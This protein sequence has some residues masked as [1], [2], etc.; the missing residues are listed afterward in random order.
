MA[1]IRKKARSKASSLPN[2]HPP[3]RLELLPIVPPFF[4]Q[5]RNAA[6][7]EG[8]LVYYGPAPTF[9]GVGEVVDRTEKSIRVNFR[10]TGQLGVHEETLHP[11][12]VLPI[13]DDRRGLL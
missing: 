10:G 13:P 9:Y 11:Q 6:V 7:S 4:R 2:P 1:M 5:A 12:Y 3:F 8:E